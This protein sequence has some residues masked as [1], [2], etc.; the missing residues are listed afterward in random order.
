[1]DRWM[2]GWLDGWMAEWLNGWMLDGVDGVDGADGVDGVDG[3]MGGWG[4]WG[5]W[6]DGRMDRQIDVQA[7]TPHVS[8]R[9]PGKQ[10]ASFLA[11][12]GLWACFGFC[13]DK[14]MR[15]SRPSTKHRGRTLYSCARTASVPKHLSAGNTSEF[16]E[17]G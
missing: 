3:W 4:G 2:D 6:V 13:H 8:F 11:A 17:A 10:D 14:P 9:K 12:Y 1:M 5:G 15:A 16:I 7:Q